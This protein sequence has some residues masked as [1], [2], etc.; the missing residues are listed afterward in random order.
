MC[1]LRRCKLRGKLR[2]I[3]ESQMWTFDTLISLTE[4]IQPFE[5]WKG[6][7]SLRTIAL[8]SCGTPWGW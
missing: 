1:R 7:P 6:K 8:N 2:H 4:H 5:R 3:S